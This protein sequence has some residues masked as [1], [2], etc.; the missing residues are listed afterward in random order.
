MYKVNDLFCGCGGMGLGFLG[1]GFEIVGAW[2]FD[3]YAVESYRANVG[4]HVKQADINEM[5]WNDVPKADV[6]AFGFPCP[7]FS[8]A[9][10]GHGMKYICPECGHEELMEG[11]KIIDRAEKCT[12]CGEKSVP[13]DPR[14]TL[15]FEVMRLLK[16]TAQNSPQ[17]LPAVILAENVKGI[18]KYLG[19]IENEFAKRGYKMHYTLRNSK[20]WGVPQSRERYYITGIRQDLP[21]V[22]KFKG[23]QKTYIPKLTNILENNVD[24]KYYIS[25][26]KAQKII[27]QAFQK[28]DKLGKCHATITP[29]RVDK[30]Q[31]GRRA[32]NDE[33]EMYTLTAQDLHGVIESKN[34][35]KYVCTHCDNQMWVKHKKCPRCLRGSIK[36]A[37]EQN[38]LNGV[39]TGKYGQKNG[40]TPT[41]MSPTLDASAHKGLGCNQARPAVIEVIG[42]LDIK[43]KDQTKR[44]HS[45]EGIAP[46]LTAVQGGGQ[47]VKIL[48][49]YRVRKLTPTEYGRLQ[50]FPMDKWKQV[51]SDSQAYKQFGNAVTVP[52][53][54]SIARQIKHYL[55]GIEYGI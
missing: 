47:E 32:K 23:E 52:V 27:E 2:D 3:K 43:G 13:I 46:T 1:A 18:K 48:Q 16:E 24:E 30:R 22:F 36:K 38:D 42:R 8:V 9:G 39:I 12:K 7:S 21:Q 51:V 55:R 10:K 41:E 28:L 6:W 33:E 50:G 31:N 15:L 14:G 44:V 4:E 25:E 37:I 5:K 35:E 49:R 53:A 29:A 20:Y 54:K 34:S 45:P 26:E 19:I 40:F 11:E 17:Q